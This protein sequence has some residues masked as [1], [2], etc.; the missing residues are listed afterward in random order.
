[1][2]K[3]SADKSYI[4]N[5]YKKIV[6]TSLQNGVKDYYKKEENT[7]KYESLVDD[8]S[9]LRQTY[10]DKYFLNENKIV[11]MNETIYI[12]ND[13]LFEGLLGLDVTQREIVYLSIYEELSDAAISERLAIHRRTVQRIRKKAFEFLKARMELKSDE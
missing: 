12:E 10:M 2:K 8:F 4:E 1:M 7:E 6:N 5:R 3:E 9:D 11:I 13:E